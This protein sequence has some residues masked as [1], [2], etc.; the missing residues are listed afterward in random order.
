M[1]KKKCVICGKELLVK[2]SHAKKGWGKYCSIQCHAKGQK[3]GKWVECDYCGKKVYRTPKDFKRSKNKR[4]FCSVACHCSW[5]NKNVRCGVNAPN[6]KAGE[7]AYRQLLRRAGIKEVCRSCGNPDKRVLAVHHKDGNRKNNN[8]N[9]LEWLCR[10]CH[11]IIH[12]C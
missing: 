9:N 10:N 1:V 3:K 11:C 8:V 4:F 6:W 2:E 12:L 5:E 7:T